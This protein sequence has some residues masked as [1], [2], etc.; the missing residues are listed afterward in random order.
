M[1][2]WDVCERGLALSGLDSKGMV[3][4]FLRGWTMYSLNVCICSRHLGFDELRDLRGVLR[5]VALAKGTTSLIAGTRSPF[6]RSA[7]GNGVVNGDRSYLL[8]LRSFSPTLG[9][10][11]GRI[12]S[13]CKRDKHVELQG[14]IST[15]ASMHNLH[16]SRRARNL[17]PTKE[18]S[19][20]KSLTMIHR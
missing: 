1:D 4:I 3:G 10:A 8:V 11:Y 20:R 18:V 7:V 5:A 17:F 12:G 14:E 19:N 13:D 15:G 9:I 16:L 2:P 6:T